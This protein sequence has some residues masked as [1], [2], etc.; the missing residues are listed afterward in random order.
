MYYNEEDVIIGVVVLV[1]LGLILAFGI[2]SYVLCSLSL[3]QVGKRRGVRLYGLA[4]V[5]VASAWVLG[6]IADIYDGRSRLHHKWRHVLLWLA[7]ILAVC[8]AVWMAFYGYIVVEMLQGASMSAVDADAMAEAMLN[9][10]EDWIF[11]IIAVVN[12]LSLAS[13]AYIAC[14]YICIYKFF[15]SCRPHSTITFLLLSL[16]LSVTFPF[17]MFACRNWDN[18]VNGKRQNRQVYLPDVQK[19][20]EN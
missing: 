6:G 2:L 16:I 13:V 9:D 19:P 7:V 10:M 3:F 5:P 17:C 1:I 12:I 11:V 20:E 14:R 15:E 18:G 8:G 4:W